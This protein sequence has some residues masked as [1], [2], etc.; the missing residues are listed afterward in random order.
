M[1]F[2][3]FLAGNRFG[4]GKIYTWV[5]VSEKDYLFFLRFFFSGSGCMG[6]SMDT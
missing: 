4:H 5:Y 2:D 1:T 3:T 6:L